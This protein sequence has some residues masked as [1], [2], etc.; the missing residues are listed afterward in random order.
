[1][2]VEIEV[3]EHCQVLM[4]LSAESLLEQLHLLCINIHVMANILCQV[5][6]LLVVLIGNTRSLLQV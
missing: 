4:E 3:V 6:E 5:V 2:L 1:L